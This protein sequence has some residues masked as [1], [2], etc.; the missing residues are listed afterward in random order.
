MSANTNSAANNTSNNDTVASLADVAADF[1]IEDTAAFERLLY[2]PY[3]YR[4]AAFILFEALVGDP[5]LGPSDLTD[6][7][8]WHLARRSFLI[9]IFNTHL[10][11]RSA[12]DRSAPDYPSERVEH[13][14]A[15]VT[16]FFSAMEERR[17]ENGLPSWRTRS[18]AWRAYYAIF[19]SY[20]TQGQAA[21][22]DP[23]AELHIVRD[24]L[25]EGSLAVEWTDERKEKLKKI[26]DAVI[27]YQEWLCG[28]EEYDANETL[29]E[30]I[31]RSR[32]SIPREL[33]NIVVEEIEE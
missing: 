10:L 16:L 20:L 9:G 5:E 33:D 11:N 13:N 25:T 32:D 22:A 15:P 7:C 8:G 30:T 19:K 1:Y 23:F 2:D 12:P 29:R 31:M 21:V 27:A 18:Q 14:S 26:V 28:P 6:F 4:Y 24:Y 3:M 17:S